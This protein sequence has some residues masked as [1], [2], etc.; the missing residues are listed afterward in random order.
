MHVAVAFR[1]PEEVL[2]ITEEVQVVS[3]VHPTVICFRKYASARSGFP[4]SK[5]QR[6]LS[7]QARHG[8]KTQTAPIREPFRTHDVLEWL[9]RYLNPGL[10]WVFE[11]GYSQAHARI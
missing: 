8:L 11:F 10:A 3:H 5:I 4:I 1:R 6:Q 2:S 7:L 9:V